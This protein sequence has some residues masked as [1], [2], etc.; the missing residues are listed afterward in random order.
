M[1]KKLTPEERQVSIDHLLGNCDCTQDT[2]LFNEANTE[3]LE[4]MTD[5]QLILLVEN[6]KMVMEAVDEEEEEVEYEEME[7]EEE[8]VV[9]P[10]RKMVAK[11]V[12][13]AITEEDLPAEMQE[14]LKFARNMRQQ[15]KDQL[16]GKIT[17]NAKGSLFTEKEL[18]SKSVDE[19]TKLVSLIGNYAPGTRAPEKKTA[20]RIGGHASVP[21]SN[22]SFDDNDIL[23]LP[24]INFGSDN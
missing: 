19:L 5:A 13:N 18:Q 10:K 21:T 1:A 22:Q 12:A 2:P 16:V 15:Q 24:T 9:P 8:V 7:E 11:P 3:V 4:S 6:S 20:R 17:T 23:E 14:D